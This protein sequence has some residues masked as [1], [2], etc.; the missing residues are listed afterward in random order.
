MAVRILLPRPI[1]GTVHDLR[2][3]PRASSICS[4]EAAIDLLERPKENAPAR[5]GKEQLRTIQRR[6][7]TWRAKVAHQLISNA[8]AVIKIDLLMVAP[9]SS[10]AGRAVEYASA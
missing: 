1:G 7:K 8:E 2:T 6:L 5:F 4:G 10:N 3:F 9:L